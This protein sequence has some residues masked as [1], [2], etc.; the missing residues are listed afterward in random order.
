MFGLRFKRTR[1]HARFGTVFH[2]DVRPRPIRFPGPGEACS[3]LGRWSSALRS[4]MGQDVGSGC[5][6]LPSRTL[7]DYR[8]LRCGQETHLGVLLDLEA[9]LDSELIGLHQEPKVSSEDEGLDL[10]SAHPSTLRYNSRDSPWWMLQNI[11]D[12]VKMAPEGISILAESVKRRFPL[13]DTFVPWD[14]PIAYSYS[15]T[16][17]EVIQEILQRHALGI[18]CREHNAG[19]NLD[20]QMK[21]EGFDIS[22]RVDWTTGIIYGGSPYN[23][24]TWMDKMGE[25]V[26]AG[27][28]GVPGT[29]RD[30]APIEIIGLLKSTLTWLDQLASTGHFPF[31]GVEAES[32]WIA[33][34]RESDV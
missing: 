8:Q 3:V 24:G 14:D 13:D 22:I 12:Y 6:H 5:L 21:D 7:L 9:R 27:T 33:L 29:P 26:K 28:K 15:S 31:T 17:A 19:P 25:S 11:Q 30:G 2:S 18:N 34:F 10:I 20:M 4:W 23:C 16:V 1:L 32:E